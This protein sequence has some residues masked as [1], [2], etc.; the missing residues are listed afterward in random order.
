MCFKMLLS[1][2]SKIVQ[3]SQKLLA[4]CSLLTPCVKYKCIVVLDILLNSLWIYF[5]I[6]SYCKTI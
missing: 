3:R 5:Y 1:A 4:S 6:V 2:K